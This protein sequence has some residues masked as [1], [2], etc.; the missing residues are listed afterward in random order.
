MMVTMIRLALALLIASAS[1]SIAAGNGRRQRQGLRGVKQ[2]TAADSLPSAGRDLET[3][4]YYLVPSTGFCQDEMYAPQWITTFFNDWNECCRA[5]WVVEQCMSASPD[6][7]V[8]TTVEQPVVVE[9]TTTTTTTTTSKSEE[10]D[11]E[12]I[13]L[14]FSLMGLPADI[15][16]LGTFKD[17]V[18]KQ[19]KIVLTNIAEDIGLKVTALRSSY[20]LVSTRTSVFDRQLQSDAKSF[21]AEQAQTFK[22]YYDVDVIKDPSQRFGPVVIRLVQERHDEILGELQVNSKYYLSNFDLCTTTRAGMY[23]DSDFDVCTLKH[24]IIP[25]KFRSRRLHPNVDQAALNDELLK[26]YSDVLN[27]IPGLEVVSLSLKKVDE[28]SNS[29]DVYIDADIVD[30]D[31]R[32]WKSIIESELENEAKKNQILSQAKQYLM[33]AVAASEGGESLEVCIDDQ[34]ILSMDCTS[35][36]S[37]NFKLPNWAIITIAS[38]CVAIV[39]IIAI[40]LCICAYQDNKDE[41]EMKYNIKTFVADPEEW[42]QGV[43]KKEKR[44]KSNKKVAPSP[45]R[46]RH[47]YH[48]RRRRHNP[49]RSTYRRHSYSPERRRS[50]RRIKHRESRDM[51]LELPALPHPQYDR[52]MPPPQNPRPLLALPPPVYEQTP[53]PEEEIL[54]IEGPIYCDDEE[55]NRHEA[56]PKPDP[57]M[58][59]GPTLMLMNRPS[60]GSGTT[61]EDSEAFLAITPGSPRHRH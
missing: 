56:A 29:L 9:E 54:A 52:P 26:I 44:K 20:D 60:H 22:A 48:E 10:D 5:G 39:L 24:D 57:P 18:T 21:S 14:R 42:R 8:S 23:D 53:S 30:Y 38:V 37:S 43:L 12:T 27:T 40:S 49:R 35:I 19:L 36:K 41:E 45:D 11:L 25:L 34:G 16:N 13:P 1:I 2:N 17:N 28:S 3:R 31:G 32:N 47:T 55:V 59:P 58:D 46:R 15:D 4:R 7:Y 6:R 61:S 50:A 51:P 33:N